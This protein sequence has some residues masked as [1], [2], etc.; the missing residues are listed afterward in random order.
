M[1][2]G[3]LMLLVFGVRKV[4]YPYCNTMVNEVKE[5]I[6]DELVS[7]VILMIIELFFKIHSYA[8]VLA[9]CPSRQG[10]LR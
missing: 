7:E 8:L 6:W 2:T 3:G 4:Y 9:R 1:A 10:K 5:R